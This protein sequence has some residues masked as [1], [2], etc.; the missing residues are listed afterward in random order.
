MASRPPLPSCLTGSCASRAGTLPRDAIEVAA[1]RKPSRRSFSDGTDDDPDA[2]AICRI[3]DAVLR[4]FC[5]GS[6]RPVVAGSAFDGGGGASRRCDALTRCAETN[7]RWR[8]DRPCHRALLSPAV[9]APGPSPAT[10]SKA[11][12]AAVSQI[13]FRGDGCRSRCCDKLP[14]L[15]R[16]DL[17]PLRRIC[18]T[19]GAGRA[20][21]GRGGRPRREKRS[22]Q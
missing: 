1:R 19:A 17:F 16:D 18:E 20:F 14:H 5:G 3:S 22:T 12:P 8:R 9:L 7:A 2:A 13:L 15:R 21:G 4:P 10:P 6:A 11:L